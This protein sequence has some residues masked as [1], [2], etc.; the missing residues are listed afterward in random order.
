MAVVLH[1]LRRRDEVRSTMVLAH[2]KVGNFILGSKSG[3]ER[4]G[5]EQWEVVSL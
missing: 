2:V 5:K 3:M 1:M 4:C